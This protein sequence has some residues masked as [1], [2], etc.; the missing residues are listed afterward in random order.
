MGDRS[1]ERLR[2][3]SSAGRGLAFR[4]ALGRHTWPVD[5]ASWGVSGVSAAA[6]RLA[7]RV[8]AGRGLYVRCS[9]RRLKQHRVPPVDSIT[10]FSDVTTISSHRAGTSGARAHLGRACV[11]RDR[12]PGAAAVHAGRSCSGVAAECD[13]TCFRGRLVFRCPSRHEGPGVLCV[14]RDERHGRRVCDRIS[15]RRHGTEGE[16]LA[17]SVTLG[18]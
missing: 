15:V 6:T 1:V 11:R 4:I 16:M 14:A 13:A 7:L 18:R 3:V 12:P 2:R 17:T 5:T 8:T 9:S 10:S